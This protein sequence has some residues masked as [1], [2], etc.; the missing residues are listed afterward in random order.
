MGI[1]QPEIHSGIIYLEDI[2]RILERV[3][4]LLYLIQVLII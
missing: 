2:E 4:Y 3:R 1:F